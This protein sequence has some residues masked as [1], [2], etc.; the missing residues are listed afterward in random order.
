M[1]S[2]VAEFLIGVL[3]PHAPLERGLAPPYRLLCRVGLRCPRSP[4]TLGPCAR[5]LVTSNPCP[6]CPARLC[7][8]GRGAAVPGWPAHAGLTVGAVAGAGRAMN[9]GAE[10]RKKPREIDRRPEALQRLQPTRRSQERHVPAGLVGSS[11]PAATLPVKAKTPPATAPQRQGAR[12]GHPGV[13]RQPG[14]ARQA[15]RVEAIVAEVG[16]RGPAGTGLLA[17]QGPD[18]RLVLDSRPVKA[19]RVRYRR[20]K[21][22]GPRWRRAVPPR[23]PAVWPQRFYGHPRRA[24][25]ATRHDRH[26]LP[27]GRIGDPS[28]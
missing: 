2:R 19:A 22:E 12:P 4:L 28:G 9:G 13:G 3:C 8:V 18:D 7:I 1:V 20:P 5:P 21:P 27:M 11:P 6:S 23:A 17:D 16:D 10:G 26:G 25:A 24:T 14:G 15:T